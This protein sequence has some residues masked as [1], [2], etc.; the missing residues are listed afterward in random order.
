M[1]VPICI[2]IFSRP[3]LIYEGPTS[4]AN[5]ARLSGKLQANQRQ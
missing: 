5:K 2:D 4:Y 1:G 3:N